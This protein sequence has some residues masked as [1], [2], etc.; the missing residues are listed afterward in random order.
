M[1]ITL[2]HLRMVQAVAED[3]TLTA[4]GKRLYLTQSALS[5]RLAELERQLGVPVFHRMGKTMVPTPAGDR[6]L[7]AAGSV[8]GRLAEL[9]TD[10]RGMAAGVKG[11]IRLTTECFT[12]YHWLPA[13]LPE[14]RAAH[15]GIEVRIVPEAAAHVEESLFRGEIDVA[16]VYD[17]HEDEALVKD[18]LFEDDQV[19]LVAPDHPLAERP[20]VVAKDLADEHLLLYLNRPSDS[21]LFQR[22]LIPAGVTPRRV[23]EVRLTEAIVSLVAAGV[24]VSVMT[25]WSAAPELRSG[26]VR[27]VRVTEFG[28][29]REWS[30]LRLKDAASPQWM[31]D[32]LN[33]L[34]RGP[35]RLFD[36]EARTKDRSVA[37]II[38]PRAG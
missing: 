35:D 23:S 8:L 2:K 20:Y 3:G 13:V 36:E 31:E 9:E 30:A 17:P 14:F 5:H 19:L 7:E 29:R 27:G 24:G 22:V 34:R 26:R 10:L 16:L 32:F 25:R 1:H 21:M 18:A 28:M 4:A 15:P 38:A 37:G 12:G 6:L 11:V 33:L